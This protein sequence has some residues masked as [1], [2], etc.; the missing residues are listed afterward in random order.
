MLINPPTDNAAFAGVAADAVPSWLKSSMRT[1]AKQMAKFW[2][3]ILFRAACAVTLARW[4][5]T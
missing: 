1:G 5:T 4:S 2:G 3:F